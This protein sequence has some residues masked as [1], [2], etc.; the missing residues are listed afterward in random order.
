MNDT[1]IVGKKIR[2]FLRDKYVGILLL[3]PALIILAFLS[4]YPFFF[5]IYLSVHDY[6]LLQTWIPKVFVGLKNYLQLIQDPLFWNTLSVTLRYA[7]IVVAIEFFLG[8]GL[9]LLVNMNIKGRNI[10]TSLLLAPII[11]S[12]IVAGLIWG[13]M[14]NPEFGVINFFLNKLFG[15]KDL[16]FLGDTRYAF[17]ACIIV[18]VWQWTPLMFLILLAGLQAVPTEPYEAAQID[19]ASPSQCFRYLTLPLI[20][21]LILISLL[22]RMIDACKI[23]DTIYILTGGGPASVTESLSLYAYRNNFVYFN[24]G[25]GAVLAFILLIL[26]T[27]FCVLF[28][29]MLSRKEI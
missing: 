8:L 28:N 9:A 11:M 13:Y 1:P 21:P 18:D 19:G 5:T 4:L 26:V 16:V 10:I 27:I 12:P 7:G 23:F 24:M 25:Y 22:L 17:L 15:V 6:F 3:L 29:R 14:Y 2:F 20:S